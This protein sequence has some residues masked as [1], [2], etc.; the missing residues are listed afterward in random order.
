MGD[1][2][3]RGAPLFAAV[4]HETTCKPGRHGDACGGI[5]IS[6]DKS[7]TSYSRVHPFLSPFGVTLIHFLTMDFSAAM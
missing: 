4:V 2:V 3:R 1:F 6:L 5:R 7:D